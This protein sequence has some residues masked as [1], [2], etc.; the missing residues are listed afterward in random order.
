MFNT[1][2]FG[3]CGVIDSPLRGSEVITSQ[4]MIHVLSNCSDI[5]HV[6]CISLTHTL[7]ASSLGPAAEAAAGTVFTVSVDNLTEAGQEVCS[8]LNTTAQV[9]NLEPSPSRAIH[10]QIVRAGSC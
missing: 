7:R 3:Y 1:A 5:T 6:H 10:M 4:V 2:R 9:C 8:C